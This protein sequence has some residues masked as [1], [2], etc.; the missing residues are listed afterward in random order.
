MKR[1][2]KGKK[3]NTETAKLIDFYGD[4]EGFT[5]WKEYLYRKKTGEFFLH[6]MGGP[7]TW[8]AEHRGSES[9]GSELIIPLS[10]E[11]ARKW[12]EKYSEVDLY[13]EVFGEVEE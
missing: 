13:E 1:I 10:L 4:G 7:L 11:E 8:Y 3:Y 6:G 2:I 12:M 5:R 9:W